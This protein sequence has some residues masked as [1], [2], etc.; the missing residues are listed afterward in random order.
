[1]TVIVG[2]RAVVG[3]LW[4]LEDRATARFFDDFYRHLARGV[5]LS[6]ALH[7]AQKDQIRRGAPPSAWAGIVVIGDGSLVPVPGRNGRHHP[8]WPIGIA[9]LLLALAIGLAA[10]RNQA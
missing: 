4:R 3:S 6:E 8:G 7:R 2:A 1:M 10:R 5:S 9:V